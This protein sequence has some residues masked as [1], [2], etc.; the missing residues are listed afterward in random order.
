MSEY[1]EFHGDHVFLVQMI[2]N[3]ARISIL[4]NFIKN[5]ILDIFHILYI[6]KKEGRRKM[7]AVRGGTSYWSTC[8]NLDRI[9]HWQG[10]FPGFPGPD[11]S[12]SNL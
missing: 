3:I 11:K 8:G 2:P 7:G 1:V 9:C 5:C 10:G 6:K 4:I 12:I